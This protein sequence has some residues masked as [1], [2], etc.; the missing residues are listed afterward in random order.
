MASNQS[1]L[2]ELG[3]ISGYYHL[4]FHAPAPQLCT[5]NGTMI[6]WAGLERLKA[7]E[8]G[9]FVNWSNEKWL[10]GLGVCWE[11]DLLEPLPRLP[12]GL[13]E[14]NQVASMKIKVKSNYRRYN[15]NMVY[16]RG[17]R[18]VI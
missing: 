7:I 8:A 5:D 4:D 11:T 12:L 16:K 18:T 13:D 1:L 14:S 6:A 3:R 2:T 10:D 15:P 17:R 9:R